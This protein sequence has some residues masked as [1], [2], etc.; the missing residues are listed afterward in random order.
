MPYQAAVIDVMIASPGDVEAERQIVRDVIHEWNSI[1]SRHQRIVLMPIAWETHSSPDSGDRPQAI[2]NRQLLA[3]ADVVIAV[4][5]T[6]LGSSTGVAESGTVEEIEAHLKA[7]KPA[8]IYFSDAPAHLAK[9]D[10]VQYNSV[11]SFKQSLTNRGLYQEYKTIEEFRDKL[12]RQLAQKILERFSD[13]EV[14][15]QDNLSHPSALPK[16]SDS[17]K[18]LLLEASKD[19]QGE[20]LRLNMLAGLCIQT[21]KRNFVESMNPR[22]RAQWEAAHKELVDLGLLSDGGKRGEVF[23]LTNKG[24]STAEELQ[25]D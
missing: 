20:V 2:I 3:N 25:K 1:N 7:A 16:I 6:R 10:P 17:A 19:P 22:S 13:A 23:R 4:F 8:M 5:W 24:Y 21:N 12:R 15:D 14:S 9:V 18:A 11:K